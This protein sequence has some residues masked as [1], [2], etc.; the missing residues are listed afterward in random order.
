MSPLDLAVQACLL[1]VLFRLVVLLPLLEQAMR[2]VVMRDVFSGL[3]SVLGLFR[4]GAVAC[5]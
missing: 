1:A 4:W 5:L 3:E 2:C